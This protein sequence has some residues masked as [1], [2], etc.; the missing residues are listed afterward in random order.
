MSESETASAKAGVRQAQ[1]SNI[2]R[3]RIYFNQPKGMKSSDKF[4]LQDRKRSLLNHYIAARIQQGVIFQQT[5]ERNKPILW[6]NRNSTVVL[7]LA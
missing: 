4:R 7:F 2:R 1:A 5:S 3:G 6:K